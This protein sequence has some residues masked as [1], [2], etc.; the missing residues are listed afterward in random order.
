MS[1]EQMEKDIAADLA[2]AGL[3]GV[4]V[5]VDETEQC[6][7]TGE[8]ANAEQ[9]AQAMA[10]ALAHEPAAVQNGLSYPGQEQHHL[11]Q[12][13]SI[14]SYGH[15]NHDNPDPG[16][17]ILAGADL[18]HRVFDAPEVTTLVTGTPID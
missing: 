5:N 2:K 15:A 10:I 6:Y 13:G 7:L 16:V 4:A 17:Q 12:D 14:G 1:S 18:R 8:V 9:E 3:S 11:S